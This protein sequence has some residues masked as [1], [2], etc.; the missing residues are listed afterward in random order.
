MLITILSFYSCF[1]PQSTIF[2]HMIELAQHI[3]A[4]LLENECVIVPGLGGFIAHHTTSMW[5]EKEAI[6][7]APIR[8]IG[9]NPQLQLNDGILVQ[10][11]MNTYETNFS[12]ASKRLQ[13]A[14]DQLSKTL[15]EE[16]KIEL[17]NIGEIRYTIRQTYEFTPF[18]HKLTTPQLYGFDSFSMQT[19]EELEDALEKSLETANIAASAE[20]AEEKRIGYS[21]W[22]S[23]VA[24]IAIVVTCFLISS[25]VE[26]TFIEKNNYANLMPAEFFGRIVNQSAVSAPL[27]SAHSSSKKIIKPAPKETHTPIQETPQP[28]VDKPAVVVTKQPEAEKPQPVVAVTPTQTVSTGIYHIIVAGG[29]SRANA[30]NYATELTGQGYAQ[31]CVL[32]CGG[33]NRVSIMSFTSESEANQKLFKLREEGFKDA[34]LF[35]NK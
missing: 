30:T 10:S 29:V 25:P 3:E 28:T 9:F 17:P 20:K 7:T 16:G 22:V 35:I 34:W 8:T 5:D 23:A 19:L 18:H 32:E 12:D 11:Y 14:V 4:L 13:R 26:N 27:F 21:Y 1:S 33:K 2:A 24:M 15:Y 6:F 31:A